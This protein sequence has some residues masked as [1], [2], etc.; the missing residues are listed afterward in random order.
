M[1]SDSASMPIASSSLTPRSL[2]SATTATGSVAERMTPSIIPASAGQSYATPK[3][4]GCV[5]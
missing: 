5:P 3:S 1:K 4:D 2:R